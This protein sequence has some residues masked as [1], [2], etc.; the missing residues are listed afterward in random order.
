MIKESQNGRRFILINI[1]DW[2]WKVDGSCGDGA[3]E[4][5][6]RS[7]PAWDTHFPLS[8]R[9][10]REAMGSQL[11]KIHTNYSVL[12]LSSPFLKSCQLSQC[13]QLLAM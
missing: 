12:C 13:L 4:A 10:W 2:L 1:L 6:W 3:G 5:R 8:W 11:G 7:G 9:C